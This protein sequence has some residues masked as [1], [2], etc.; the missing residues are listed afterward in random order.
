MHQAY[1]AA[2]LR[3]ALLTQISRCSEH[4]RDDS[5]AWICTYSWWFPNL[6]YLI[7]GVLIRRESYYWGVWFLG[8]HNFVNHHF[9]GHGDPSLNLQKLQCMLGPVTKQQTAQPTS[10][11][12]YK[13]AA[14]TTHEYLS[15]RDMVADRNRHSSTSRDCAGRFFSRAKLHSGNK[16][17]IP[18]K[19]HVAPSFRK[20]R[21]PR[22]PELMPGRACCHSTR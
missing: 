2:L 15:E 1:P 8:S 22:V 16:V 21:L 5:T 13:S 11:C 20:L 14:I 17:D 10:Q 7:L 9:S 4:L 12:D 3:K 19:P 18:S 6:G